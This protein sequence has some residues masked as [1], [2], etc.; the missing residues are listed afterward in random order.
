MIASTLIPC[1]GGFLISARDVT[2]M[3][4]DFIIPVILHLGNAWLLSAPNQR[5][6]KFI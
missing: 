6:D 3:I 1:V 5:I 4:Q 2:V